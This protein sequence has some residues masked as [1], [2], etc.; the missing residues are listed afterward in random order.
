MANWIKQHYDLG[1]IK[2]N[3][4]SLITY[5]Y[6]TDLPIM[7]IAPSCGS[8]TSV[9][10]NITNKQVIATF[11]VGDIPKHLRNIQDYV[12]ISKSITVTFENNVI[13]ILS[14]S[15]RIIK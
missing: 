6:T 12:N 3:T 1:P 4:K 13:D 9:V 2:E 11:T 10:H 5:T 7:S 14:F 15:G 8:C